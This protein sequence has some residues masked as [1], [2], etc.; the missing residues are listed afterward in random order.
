MRSSQDHFE[1][2][3]SIA[4][5]DVMTPFA[6]PEGMVTLRNSSDLETVD[7]WALPI[8][9]MGRPYWNFF[10][11]G[12]YYLC[13]REVDQEAVQRELFAVDQL[14]AQS[15]SRTGSALQNEDIGIGSLLTST[16]LLSLIFWLQQRYYI[17][18]PGR[19]DAL[20]IF[21]N[22]EWYRTATALTL[23]GDVGHLLS[24]CVSLLGFGILL[25]RH[26]SA[27][28]AWTLIFVSGVFGN[29]VNAWFYYPEPHFS[30]GASTAVFGGLGLLTGIG[31]RLS[32]GS[33]R[34]QQ[35]VPAWSVPLIAGAT[36]LGLLGIGDGLTR[37]V[38]IFAHF[39]GFLVGL[40]LG[41][42]FANAGRVIAF[43]KRWHY[44][45]YGALIA[46]LGIC[47]LVALN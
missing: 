21:Q 24:N 16:L 2:E 34:H 27:A 35:T 18:E 15:R 22:G 40:V 8:L 37:S 4:S 6:C 1:Y 31:I 7:S 41:M 10:H 36:L 43:M 11:L 13:V 45:V 14:E 47:W 23:H 32:L 39:S 26:F 17:V 19:A 25:S 3:E 44:P 9:A 12:H 29:A 20:R 30:I 38:D 33:L 28:L 42:I 5:D 46:S